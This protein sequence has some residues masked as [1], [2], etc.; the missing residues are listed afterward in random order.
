MAWGCSP[1][2]GLL[3]DWRGAPR[4]TLVKVIDDTGRRQASRGLVEEGAP[5]PLT[6]HLSSLSFSLSLALLSTASHADHTASLA[7]RLCRRRR[8]W[9]VPKVSRTVKYHSWGVTIANL[10]P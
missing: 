5:M 4:A 2:S 1:P 9:S 8:W 7:P 6:L 10:R 3:L